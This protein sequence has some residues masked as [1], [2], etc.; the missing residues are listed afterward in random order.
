MQAKVEERMERRNRQIREFLR[1]RE[2]K[3]RLAREREE[4]TRRIREMEEKYKRDLNRSRNIKNPTK[5][6]SC[7]NKSTLIR[8]TRVVLWL[9][10]GRKRGGLI[11]VL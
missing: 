4:D 8:R 3:K 2:V 7:E 6:V 10:L 5:A 9:S 11:R 1:E